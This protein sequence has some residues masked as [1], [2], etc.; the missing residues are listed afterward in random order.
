M[1]YA[2]TPVDIAMCR[3]SL[4]DYKSANPKVDKIKQSPLTVSR[5][6]PKHT[7]F[8]YY[9]YTKRAGGRPESPTLSCI[10]HTLANF[11]D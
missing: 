8:M 3:F 5:R 9:F 4:W 2:S 1:K 6:C 10:H 7:K 11:Q